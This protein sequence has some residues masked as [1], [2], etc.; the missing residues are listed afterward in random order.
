[1][2]SWDIKETRNLVTD[3]FGSEQVELVRASLNSLVERRDFARYHFQEY[4]SI[5]VTHIDSKFG[6]KHILELTLP[7]HNE[8]CFSIDNALNQAAANVVACLQSLH[9]ITDTLSYALYYA[10]GLNMSGTPLAPHRISAVTVKNAFAEM[11]NLSGVASLIGQ[12]TDNPTLKH[13]DA[14]VN[15]SKHRSIVRPS[16]N[17]DLRKSSGPTYNLEFPSIEYKGNH[18]PIADVQEFM[19]NAYSVLSSQVNATGNALNAALRSMRSTLGSEAGGTKILT[20][21]ST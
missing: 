21:P 20:S 8:E 5:L 18:Y 1:M 10:V 2:T 11:A 4:K 19:E 16:L 12:I 6:E 17:V 14:L 3:L 15:H 9:C 13:L 7:L